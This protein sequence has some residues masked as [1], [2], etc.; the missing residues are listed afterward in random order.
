MYQKIIL[1]GNLGRNVELRHT[2]SGT[3]V[4]DLSIATNEMVKGEKV[5]T[6]WKATVWDKL[7]E[8]CNLYIRKGSLVLVEGIMKPGPGGN[9]RTYPK[10]DGSTGASYEMRAYTVKFLDKRE[11][12]IT[13][14]RAMA[15][16]FDKD[17]K[18][19]ETDSDDEI[20]F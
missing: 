19:D 7:A 4:A 15:D 14:E 8:N 16:V 12:G 17:D 1:I 13:A 3:A 18:H 9:P 2:P 11:Q 20:P 10:R 6:W 5:T